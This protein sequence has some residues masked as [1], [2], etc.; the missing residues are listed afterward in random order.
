MNWRVGR[1]IP[2]NVYDGERPVCQCQTAMDAKRI[3]EAMNR[4]APYE[5]DRLRAI[6]A[7]VGTHAAQMSMDEFRAWLFRSIFV[8]SP[9]ASNETEL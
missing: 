1:K 7:D 3:V 5:V 8:I 4:Q 2:I 6:L 9:R